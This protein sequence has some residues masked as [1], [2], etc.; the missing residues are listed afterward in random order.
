[1]KYIIAVSVAIILA[2]LWRLDSVT[3]SRDLLKEK[4]VYQASE[5]LKL[6]SQITRQQE[7]IDQAAEL[8]KKHTKELNH[9]LADNERL[10]NAD[11]RVFIKASCPELPRADSTTSPTGVDDGGRAELSPDSRQTVFELRGKLIKSEA[12]LDGLQDYIRTMCR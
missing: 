5:L 6:S 12:K 1:M 4:A 2:L 8:D 9:A 7:K 11:N 3:G 10:A